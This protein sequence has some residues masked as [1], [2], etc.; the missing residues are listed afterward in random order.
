M[1]KRIVVCSDG[2]GNTSI[3][4]RGTNVFKLFEAVD[5]NGHR[6]DAVLTPQIALYDD[7]VGTEDFKPL[8]I[9]AGLT[10][11]GLS[12]NV[13][14]LYKELARVYDPGDEIYMFGFS[15]GAFTVRTLVGFI[16]TCGVINPQNLTVERQTGLK[17][18]SGRPTRP[19]GSAIG[20]SLRSLSWESRRQ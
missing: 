7:G 3:K 9:F 14:R 8:K 6:F 2:T 1:A 4:G 16:A 11:F 13:R 18:R 12:R 17:T 19:T 20:P 5:L 15:R 10:G